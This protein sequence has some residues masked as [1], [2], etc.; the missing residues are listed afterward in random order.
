MNE[1]MRVDLFDL[2]PQ[3]CFNDAAQ[4]VAEEQG[5]KGDGKLKRAMKLLAGSKLSAA[6]AEKFRELDLLALFAQGWAQSP[7]IGNHEASDG[8]AKFVRLGKFEHELDLFPMLTISMAGFTSEPIK[9]A[10]TIQAE[11]EAVEVGLTKGYLVE[12]GGGFATLSAL[13]KYGGF[14]FP[15]GVAPFE[16]QLSG[17]RKFDQPGIKLVGKKS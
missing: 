9:L 3:Q 2:V 8:K 17:G 10:L 11:F 1:P 13:L 6:M 12:I 14:S 4:K 16:W 7:E 15:A 5:E